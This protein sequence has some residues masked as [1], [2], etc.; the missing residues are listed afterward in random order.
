MQA[1]QNVNMDPGTNAGIA[2]RADPLK[3]DANW[4]YS[5]HRTLLCRPFFGPYGYFQML[6]VLTIVGIYRTFPHP[7]ANN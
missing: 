2:R 4:S 1:M 5:L 6:F 7:P 3:L